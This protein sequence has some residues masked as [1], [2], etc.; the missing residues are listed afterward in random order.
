MF[1]LIMGIIKI[2]YNLQCKNVIVSVMIMKIMK[3]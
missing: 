1:K 2:I 3:I